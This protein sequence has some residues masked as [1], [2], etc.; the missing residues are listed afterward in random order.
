MKFNIPQPTKFPSEEYSSKRI[1]VLKPCAENHFHELIH[2]DLLEKCL[3][4]SL[5]EAD[6]DRKTLTCA[7]RVIETIFSLENKD[8]ATV[9]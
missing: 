8:E 4:G 9:I 2:I 5:F 3:I 6:L 1:E 7:D